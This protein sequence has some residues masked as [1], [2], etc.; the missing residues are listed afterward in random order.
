M[1]EKITISGTLEINDHQGQQ[2]TLQAS[3]FQTDEHIDNT[4][5]TT[6]DYDTGDWSVER[7]A[8]KKDGVL[9]LGDW[10]VE[11]CTIITD[12]ITFS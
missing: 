6:F 2:Q 3:D 4:N 11:S 12:D 5:T 10:S 8:E 1:N 9:S 7:T